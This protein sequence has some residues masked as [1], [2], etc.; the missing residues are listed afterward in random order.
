MV[1]TLTRKSYPLLK[2]LLPLALLVLAVGIFLFFTHTATCTAELAA[3]GEKCTPGGTYNDHPTGT[4]L[5][6]VIAAA[7]VALA[8]L[9]YRRREQYTLV[10]PTDQ[11]HGK[12]RADLEKVLAGLEEARAKGDITQD[13]YTKARDRVLAEMKAPAK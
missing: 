10:F 8:S 11:L 12:S 2:V 4:L 6:Y 13:R 5:P 1:R 7:V 3:N 9:L